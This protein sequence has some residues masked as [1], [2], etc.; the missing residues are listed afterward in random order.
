MTLGS[1]IWPVL[2][3]ETNCK[4]YIDAGL[5]TLGQKYLALN[6]CTRNTWPEHI[7][8]QGIASR[9]IL[10]WGPYPEK[11]LAWC[12]LGVGWGVVL[13]WLGLAAVS[14]SLWLEAQSRPAP[15]EYGR[16]TEWL[17]CQRFASLRYTRHRHFPSLARGSV[18]T[19]VPCPDSDLERAKV[20]TYFIECTQLSQGELLIKYKIKIKFKTL[21]EPI[22]LAGSY[23]EEPKV[24]VSVP[25]ACVVSAA[26]CWEVLGDPKLE[27]CCSKKFRLCETSALQYFGR[28]TGYAVNNS[29]SGSWA[30]W[31]S[32]SWGESVLGR[33]SAGWGVREYGSWV[34]KRAHGNDEEDSLTRCERVPTRRSKIHPSILQGM[35]GW[36]FRERLPQQ[37]LGEFRR[38]NSRLPY[39]GLGLILANMSM[40]TR[41]YSI[42]WDDAWA[43]GCLERPPDYRR[44]TAKPTELDWIG[45]EILELPRGIGLRRAQPTIPPFELSNRNPEAAL[46]R[47]PQMDCIPRTTYGHGRAGSTSGMRSEQGGR[48]CGGEGKREG[49]AGGHGHGCRARVKL[50]GVDYAGTRVH[51]LQRSTTAI[52]AHGANTTC[53]SM[54]AYVDEAGDGVRARCWIE[55]GAESVQ[56]GGRGLKPTAVR[57][58]VA[59]RVH[60]AEGWGGCVQ[61]VDVGA[62]LD[63]GGTRHLDLE[64]CCGRI[65]HLLDLVVARDVRAGS[66]TGR[67]CARQIRACAPEIDP[68]ILVGMLG[69]IL[70]AVHFTANH[71]SV[72]SIA[73][74]PSLPLQNCLIPKGVGIGRDSAEKKILALNESK[75]THINQVQ[76]TAWLSVK[77]PT[78][79]LQNMPFAGARRGA[80]CQRRATGPG[81]AVHVRSRRVPLKSTQASPPRCSGGFQGQAS[82]THINYASREPPIVEDLPWVEDESTGCRER[83]CIV[84]HDYIEVAVEGF[85][86]A[87]PGITVNASNVQ[88]RHQNDL[89]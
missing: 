31:R 64:F 9:E 26:S 30:M 34:P 28:Y 82:M 39:T 62:W 42:Q 1:P 19:C 51:K 8:G 21:T 66:R 56:E 60:G 49:V 68:S 27:V 40:Y 53:T 35:L 48:G 43:C 13:L 7:T 5:K 71:R 23:A 2:S 87:R 61:R 84:L 54:R 52:D 74:L 77:K 44:H 12:I 75:Q 3:T 11:H 67:G 10:G 58:E 85:V 6:S 38:R 72:L 20:V 50:V 76:L 83:K 78:L 17:R 25:F 47:I 63:E 22:A 70:G 24:G 4:Q 89:F 15:H 81:V 88:R 18:T 29:R 65:C 59:R 33:R 41:P 80:G 36:I 86:V 46:T 45:F 32:D 37:R 14:P 55:G 73:S 69:W 16:M 57:S 79:V